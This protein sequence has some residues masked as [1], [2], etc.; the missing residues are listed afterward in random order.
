MKALKIKENKRQEITEKGIV[1]CTVM[2]AK[3]EADVIA[4]RY[5]KDYPGFVEVEIIE[6]TDAQ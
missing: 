5:K 1:I 4:E 3:G 2:T 6:E